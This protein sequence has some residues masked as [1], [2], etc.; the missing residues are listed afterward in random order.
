[1]E[2]KGHQ[3]KQDLKEDEECPVCGQINHDK[4]CSGGCRFLNGGKR[5]CQAEERHDI[6]T[7]SHRI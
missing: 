7:S 1:M 4:R 2:K 3:L 5:I 6:F